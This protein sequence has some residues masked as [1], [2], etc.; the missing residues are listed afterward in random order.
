MA[1]QIDFTCTARCL[2]RCISKSIEFIT[3]LPFY[4]Q[5]SHWDNLVVVS[6]VPNR[7]GT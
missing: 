1:L 2:N 6:N 7:P 5:T 3:E 4:I